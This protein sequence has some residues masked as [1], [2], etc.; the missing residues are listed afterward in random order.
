MEGQAGR[1]PPTAR[2]AARRRKGLPNWRIVRYADDFAVLVHGTEAG[3]ARRCARR[4]PA[5]SPRWGCGLSRGQD[6][7]GAHERGVQFPGVPHPVAP[8]AGNE[9]VVRLHLHRRPAH[10]VAEGEDPCPDPQDITAGPGIRADQAEP[11]HARLGQLLPARRRQE[12]LRHAGQLRLVAGDPHAEGHG[13]A[14]GGRTSAAG[15]PPPPGGGCRSRRARP[16]CGGSRRYRSPG[17]ATA[18]ARSP[19]PGPLQPA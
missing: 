14:G 6:P 2:R 10:P 9:Q 1:C 18:A 3:H 16:S 11:G 12:H 5:C 8:Q 7:R 13:T 4:S 15:S 17:T 19:A